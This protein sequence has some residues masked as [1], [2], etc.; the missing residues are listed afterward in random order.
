MASTKT[1]YWIALGV[2]AVS[3]GSSNMG[4]NLACKA[5]AVV[6][7]LTARAVPYVAAVEMAL[8]RTQAGYAH[9]QAHAARVQ[10]EQARIEAAQARLQA[11][12]AREQ[13]QDVWMS[14]RERF[15]VLDRKVIVPN[16]VVDGPDVRVTGPEHLI[17]CPRT[18]VRLAMPAAPPSEHH[19]GPDL[20]RL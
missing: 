14:N 1:L 8:G 9:L 4:R 5:S 20:N 3:L 13:F 15:E 16:V 17:V 10:A 2:L 7:H 12:M 18:K 19:A 6:D 11:E